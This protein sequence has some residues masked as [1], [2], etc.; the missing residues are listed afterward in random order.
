MIFGIVTPSLRGNL[1]LQQ[2]LELANAYLECAG[3][4]HDRGVALV[5]CYDTEVSLLYAKKDAK[6]AKD[7]SV[8]HGIANAY[9][10]LARV[11]EGQGCGTESKAI[12]KKAEKLR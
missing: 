12:Y 10:K 4:V 11:L 9:I 7:R 5:M 3:K 6:H 8:R 1:S 2:S